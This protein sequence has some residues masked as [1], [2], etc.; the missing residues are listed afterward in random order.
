MAIVPHDAD[1]ETL[2]VA[3]NCRASLTTT[4]G[5]VGRI[6]NA[7]A[8]ALDPERATLLVPA[9]VVNARVAVK[10]PAAVGL[11]TRLAEQLA[12]AARLAPQ[13]LV[14]IAKT[15]AFVPE[16][17]T[18]LIVMAAVVPLLRVADCAG[19]VAPGAVLPNDRVVGLALTVPP[20]V[21]VP[22][23]DSATVCG[24]LLAVSVKLRVAVRVPVVVGEKTMVAVQLADAARVVPQVL[25]DIL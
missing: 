5:F 7:E 9:E 22:V 8:V 25:L 20:V 1:Q 12:A 10:L 2:A 15:A 18:L 11:K 6:E 4:V 21:P 14:E 13:V 19:L 24:L 16:M 23:P 17:A 3:E